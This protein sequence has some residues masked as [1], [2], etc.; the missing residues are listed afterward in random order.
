MSQWGAATAA[1]AA[2]EAATSRRLPL[3]VEFC[4]GRSL[5]PAAC[6]PSGWNTSLAL[7]PPP[8]A[9]GYDLVSRALKAAAAARPAIT[10]RPH[11]AG[12]PSH[13]A[14]LLCPPLLQGVTGGVES[15]DSFLQQ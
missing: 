6:I 12:L 8:H 11:A 7:P 9:A 14:T 5:Q 4:S 2:A 3:H 10:D 15:M 13:P 1:A